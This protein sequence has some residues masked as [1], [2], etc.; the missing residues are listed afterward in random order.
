VLSLAEAQAIE[1]IADL[2]YEFLPG[3]GNNK[4]AYPR[5]SPVF[6]ELARCFALSPSVVHSGA[7]VPGQAA[8]SGRVHPLALGL[9]ERKFMRNRA[10]RTRP[11]LLHTVGTNLGMC[12]SP[13]SFTWPP[14]CI[15]GRVISAR[16][17]KAI[18]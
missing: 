16:C 12:R 7:R 13:D 8:S 18:D 1:N 9:C 17:Q 15:E 4:T 2:L 3:S 6:L 14:I 11:T 10:N 5:R